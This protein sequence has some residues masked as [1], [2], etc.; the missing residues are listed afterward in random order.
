M[1]ERTKKSPDRTYHSY[2]S[3][4]IAQ[5]TEF[6]VANVVL[7]FKF[8]LVLL[9]VVCLLVCLL[10]RFSVLFQILWKCALSTSVCRLCSICSSVV[11]IIIIISR[12]IV[13]D[14]A[15]TFIFSS[16]NYYRFTCL[17]YLQFLVL[18]CS[19]FYFTSSQPRMHQKN[20]SWGDASQWSDEHNEWICNASPC[21]S[22]YQTFNSITTFIC[23]IGDNSVHFILFDILFN[24]SV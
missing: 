17:P 23:L 5:T 12:F 10:I 8:S 13:F 14:F 22:K 20:A 3:N 2:S 9:S 4:N 16:L 21:T 7:I 24:I 19:F 6:T 11:I 1:N 15:S 18:K